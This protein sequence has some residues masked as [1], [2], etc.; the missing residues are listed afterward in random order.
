MGRE[1][2]EVRE[3]REA[4]GRRAG[5]GVREGGRE[6]ELRRARAHR[7]ARTWRRSSPER[8]S[9]IRSVTCWSTPRLL[10]HIRNARSS[11]LASS[12]S[13]SN[14]ASIF[15]A[16]DASSTGSIPG[17]LLKIAAMKPEEGEGEREG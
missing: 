8:I 13:S 5:A 1:M 4:G 16:S 17:Y 12:S 3:G 7:T 6:A 15:A 11:R 14:C 10:I 9:A 2:R